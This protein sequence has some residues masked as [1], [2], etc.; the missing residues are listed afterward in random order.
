MLQGA[1]HEHTEALRGAAS[2]LGIEITI[3]EL[4]K[5]SDVRGIDAVVLP[6]GESTSMRIASKFEEL[7]S[8]LW[9]EISSGIPVLGT[10][11]G[12][13]LLC[14]ENL[15]SAKIQR[16]AFGRQIDSFECQI[17]VNIGNRID[18]AEIS[19]HVRDSFGHKPLDLGVKAASSEQGFPGVFIR[20]PKFTQVACEIIATLDDE[21]VGV[22]DGNRIAV[23]FHPELTNDRRFH[24]WLISEAVNE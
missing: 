23:T 2:E 17:E 7:Y 8:H 11:A 18:A 21:V 14:Q 10:C 12:A 20:A 24:R 9:D 3:R 16:N 5:S 1:R 19:P 6:G 13:I 22:Q 15:I 4:R